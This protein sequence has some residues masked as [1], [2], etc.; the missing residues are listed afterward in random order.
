MA[1]WKSVM[2]CAAAFA[3]LGNSAAK[4]PENPTCPLQP[5]WA[6]GQK[7]TLNVQ[8]IYDE[9]I[10]LA[11]GVID[12]ELPDR[13]RAVIKKNPDIAEIWLRSPGGNARAGNA[14]GLI[15]RKEL[16]LVITRIPKGWSCFSACNFVFMG[17]KARIIED[18]GNFMVHMFTL[19]GDRDII[20]ESVALGTDTTIEL[21]GE[22]EQESALLATEDNDFLIRMGVSRKLLSEV[23][24][25]QQAVKNEEDPST[26]YCLSVEEA[27]KYNVANVSAD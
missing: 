3:L 1:I 15:I 6:A 4:D 20:D 8:E 16:G 7:M 13:L 25:R 5:D 27:F 23:M 9:K 24:Y 14:A 18:G 10:L 17:G 21:I 26:R 2:A 11:E 12:A 19:T 22:I